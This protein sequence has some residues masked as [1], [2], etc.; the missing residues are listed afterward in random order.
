MSDLNPALRSFGQ[1][2]PPCSEV[3]LVRANEIYSQLY[4]M[5]ED[6]RFIHIKRG[7]LLIAASQLVFG[8]ITVDQ[9]Q[10]LDRPNQNSDA[11]R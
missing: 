3:D 8:R 1:Y 2:R 6:D 5:L 10:L 9:F 7:V 11:A 4:S